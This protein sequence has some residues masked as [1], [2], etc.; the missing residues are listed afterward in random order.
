MNNLVKIDGEKA[1][2]TSLIIAEGLELEHRA[3]I[4][5]VRTYREDIN[6]ISLKTLEMTKIKTAGRSF[7]IA[8]LD[9]PQATFIITLMKNSKL[10]VK[11]KKRLIQEFFKQRETISRL[12]FQRENP[13]WQNARK[14]G[15]IIYRQKTDVIKKFV[16][17]STVQGSKNSKRY[18]T[19]LAKMENSALFFFEQKYKN[20]REVLTIKQL[21]QVATADDVIEKAL[22]EGMKDNLDYHDIYKLAKSRIIA[23]ADIIGQSPILGIEDQLKIC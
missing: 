21:M 12:I 23:F 13:D 22:E 11:F 5:L 9:E 2:T 7:E 14:D 6:D 4:R 3:V 17:Y 15:K 16:E 20:M 10:V 1:F 8:I 18:Y 19:T